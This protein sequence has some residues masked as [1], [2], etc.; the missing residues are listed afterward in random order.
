MAK[1]AVSKEVKEIKDYYQ[2]AVKEGWTVEIK[3]SPVI[4][5]SKNG[6]QQHVIF[7]ETAKKIIDDAR[8]NK[9]HGQCT[10]EEII[11]YKITQLIREV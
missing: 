9:Q 11:F 7:N 3:H 6:W 5:I 1:A 8:N 2:K 10:L 4:D